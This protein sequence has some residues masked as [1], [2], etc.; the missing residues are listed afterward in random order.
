MNQKSMIRIGL[1]IAG[2]GHPLS[3]A[4][5][6]WMDQFSRDLPMLVKR[7]CVTETDIHTLHYPASPAG[8]GPLNELCGKVQV[9]LFVGFNPD[10]SRE[11]LNAIFRDWFLIYRPR[12]PFFLVQEYPVDDKLEARSMFQRIYS[13]A[14]T[15][16]RKALRKTRVNQ[17]V[18]L[19]WDRLT[20]LVLDLRQFLPENPTV[21]ASN[22]KNVLVPDTGAEN[23]QERQNLLY[24]LESL[25]LSVLP[26]QPLPFD[27]GILKT[28]L[29]ESL[30]KSDLVIEIL[31][32]VGNDARLPDQT[33]VSSYQLS[34]IAGYNQSLLPS[35]TPI[36]RLLWIPPRAVKISDEQQLL[37]DTLFRGGEL[38]TGAEIIQ[39]P[40]EY[41]KKI[42]RKKIA[43]AATRVAT[44]EAKPEHP[45]VYVLAESMFVAEGQKLCE[46]LNYMGIHPV[47]SWELSQGGNIISQHY[48][49][50]VNHRGVL[51]YY[52][53]NR[54]WWLNSIFHDILK[55]PGFTGKHPDRIVSVYHTGPV[56]NAFTGIAGGIM[57]LKGDDSFAISL[58]QPFIDKLNS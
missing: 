9:V 52:P 11:V 22:G 18:R 55:A 6:K 7:L 34:V 14:D 33:S 54:R 23:Y 10:R 21:G 30:K 25:G 53:G 15:G 12:V 42:V 41:L 58:L 37:L 57:F 17:S 26:E 36:P 39:A 35:G 1:V 32:D 19:Y 49:N 2:S 8:N 3:E 4:Q 43:P 29:T 48:H 38:M 31:G 47:P 24:E 16:P 46:R 44:P 20:N 40:L 27:P 28:G 51:I 56:E 13:F 50:L 45:A 5:E